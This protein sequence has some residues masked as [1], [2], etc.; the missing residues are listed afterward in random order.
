MAEAV[1]GHEA[2]G[3]ATKRGAPDPNVK[4]PPAVKAAADRAEA[5]S[6][7]AKAAKTANDASGANEP[8]GSGVRMPGQPASPNGV[9]TANFD[10][11]NPRPPE[12]GDPRLSQ[13]QSQP[14]PAPTPPTPQTQEDWEHQFRSLKGRYDRDTEE[15]R[16]LQQQ[17]V[18]MQRLM[19]QVQPTPNSQSEGSGVRFNVAPPPPGRRVTPKEVQEYGE[20]TIDVMGRRAAEV[21]EPILT[22]LYGELQQVKR[23]I[24]GVQNTVVFDA[25]VQMY[26]DLEK[27]VPNWDA[28]N[29]HPLFHQWLDQIDPIS[30]HP[31]REF[32]NAAHNSNTT[33]QVVDIFKSFLSDVAARSPANGGGQQPGNGADT[34]QRLLPAPTPQ[35]DLMQFAAPG[36]AKTGQTTV[37]PEKPFYQA[38]DIT[39]FYRDKTSGKYT[40]RE[41]EAAALEQ[42]LI[43]AGN[44]GRIIRR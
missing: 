3:G 28:V 16:R 15:K 12:P 33:G 1:Q 41:A 23:Q 21:Y 32:L 44:E 34:S 18:D 39:Q 5:L 17:I 24:G 10:P 11:N 38:S 19:A 30:R 25:R 43:Q 4:V 13:T 9:V 26:K 20:E 29:N 27:E 35:V 6:A 36:R 37:P 31:R 22:Q 42:A 7:Q 14:P 40:G 2:V 8:I